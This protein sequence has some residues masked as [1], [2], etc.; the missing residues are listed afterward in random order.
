MMGSYGRQSLTLQLDAFALALIRAGLV[1]GLGFTLVMQWAS[2]VFVWTEPMLWWPILV[3]FP[4]LIHWFVNRIE[5]P[6]VP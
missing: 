3:S 6:V 5:E 4:A 2:M 1:T